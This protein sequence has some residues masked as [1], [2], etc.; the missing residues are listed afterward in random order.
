MLYTIFRSSLAY[1]CGAKFKGTNPYRV[2]SVI[3][4]YIGTGLAFVGESV[5]RVGHLAVRA[6]YRLD[7]QKDVD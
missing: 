5:L 6:S 4:A 2:V 3:L 1:R 7:G